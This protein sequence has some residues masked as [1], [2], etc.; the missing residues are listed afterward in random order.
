MKI[1]TYLNRL[2]KCPNKQ[3]QYDKE[4]DKWTVASGVASLS[5]LITFYIFSICLFLSVSFSMILSEILR[6]KR[7]N[8]E[9]ICIQII[10]NDITLSVDWIIGFILEPIN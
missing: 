9:F 3:Q 7:K 1:D 5:F 10:I 4:K 6:D 2:S 8:D